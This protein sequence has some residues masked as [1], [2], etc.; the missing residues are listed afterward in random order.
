M[1]V[2]YQVYISI[3]GQ[4][5]SKV[6]TLQDDCWSEGEYPLEAFDTLADAEAFVGTCQ[7]LKEM[8]K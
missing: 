6:D 2:K 4:D 7:Q 8:P 3:E 1:S 5:E